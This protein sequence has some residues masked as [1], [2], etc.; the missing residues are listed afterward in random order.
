MFKSIIYTIAIFLCTTQLRAEPWV[1]ISNIFLRS[2]IQHLA[3]IGIIK[4]PVTTFPLMWHDIAR[5]VNNVFPSQYDHYTKQAL[6]YVKH[7][8]KLAKRSQK[9]L[10]LNVAT[11]N[12]RF[13]SFGEDFRD[14]NN[15]AASTSFVFDQAAAKITTSYNNSPSDEDDVRFDGSYATFFLG[16]WVFSAG[17]QDRWWGPG[18][19]TSLSLTNN[20]RP[21]P[22]LA[23]SRK[24]AIPVSIPWTDISVPW[25]VTTFMGKMDDKRYVEETLLWGFRLN[26]NPA[27]NWEIGVT[28]L[29]Q[30]AGDNRPRDFNTFVDILKGLDNCGGNGPSVEECAAGQE[31][32]NQLAGYDI[33]WSPNFFSYPFAIHF[34][35]FAE[36]GDR[37]GG[38]SILGEERYQVGVET[39]IS[40]FDYHWKLYLEATDTYAQCNDGN[41]G[42]GEN[43][44]GD[45]YYEH[46]IYQTGM[47]YK[48]RSI[49]SLYEND[50]F[51]LV[52]GA[53]SQSDSNT[54]FEF[55][56]RWLQLN[57]DNHDKAPNNPIIGNTLT[58]IAEDLVMLSGKAQHSYRNWRF[59]LG[60]DISHSNFDRRSKNQNDINVFAKI[61][62]NL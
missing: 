41:N 11:E 5:D 57:K 48:G 46:H 27:Q 60:S 18:I 44:I 19:D 43:T 1:D 52:F 23:L 10:S 39:N 36:D 6:S 20:A 34:T 16:N 14:K 22:A 7:Q 40:A 50:A 4:T 21:M 25:T 53:I 38:L 2:N 12:K 32:G 61:E 24:S 59:T 9:T 56:L 29:A 62:Y 45:C 55:K 54:Q 49:G 58:P 3:D 31:P 51:S 30:W 28:R 13:T 37:K 33:R 47:R 8:L 17:M 42:T 26:F 15:V 35:A